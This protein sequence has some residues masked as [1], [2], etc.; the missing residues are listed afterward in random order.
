MNKKIMLFSLLGLFVLG[1]G[2]AALLDYYGQIN[3]EFNVEQAVTLDGDGCVDNVCSPSITTLYSPDTDLSGLYV[4]TNQDPDKSRDVE[5]RRTSCGGDCAGITTTYV[6]PVALDDEANW[7]EE[8]VV[9][10]EVDGTLNELFAGEGLQYT[11]TVL[12]GGIHNGAAPAVAVVNLVDGRHI[13]LF[14]GWGARTGT[15]TLEFSETVAQDTGGNTFVD[16]ALQPNGFGAWIYGSG[17]SYGDF[18]FVKG[19][20]AELDGTEEISRVW[21]MTQGVNT[22]AEDQIKSMLVKGI[23]YEFISGVSG[24]IFTVD[25]LSPKSA[26]LIQN[27]LSTTAG[28]YTITTEAIPA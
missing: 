1:F 10:L 4:L 13:I 16:F 3:L 20:T 8:E 26:F 24:D 19:D 6:K 5:L 14:P 12:D 22:G 7:G 11:Y 28:P 27:D 15:H 9:G 2:G 17:P 23:E 25:S 21:I 18:E